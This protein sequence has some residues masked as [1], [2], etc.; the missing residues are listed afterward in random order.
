FLAR[1]GTSATACARQTRSVSEDNSPSSPRL[2]FW[3]V[4]TR[5]KCG[6]RERRDAREADNEKTAGNS[7]G[8]LFSSNLLDS[9]LRLRRRRAAFR[10]PTTANPGNAHEAQSVDKPD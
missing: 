1:L 4:S 3:L 8:G 10:R 2:R 7:S 5:E 9:A 6:L